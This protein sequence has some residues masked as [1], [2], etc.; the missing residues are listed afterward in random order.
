[1]LKERNEGFPAAVGAPVFAAVAFLGGLAAYALSKE[2]PEKAQLGDV[3]A[4]VPEALQSKGKSMPT[5]LLAAGASVLGIVVGLVFPR[6]QWEG[7]QIRSAVED[8]GR[9]LETR[10]SSELWSML[11]SKTRL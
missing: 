5:I 2:K 7:R 4:K 6:T 1:M 9:K 10:A 3:A 8:F 11:K